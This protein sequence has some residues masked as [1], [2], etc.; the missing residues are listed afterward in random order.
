MMKS[1]LTSKWV[2]RSIREAASLLV[3]G[4]FNHPNGDTSDQTEFLSPLLKRPKGTHDCLGAV[5]IKISG[6]PFDSISA[7]RPQSAPLQLTKGEDKRASG[8]PWSYCVQLI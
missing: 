3:A 2:P 5:M 7:P 4:K 6:D 8:T 1:K